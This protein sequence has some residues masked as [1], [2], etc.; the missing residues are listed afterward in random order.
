VAGNVD[1]GQEMHF[2]L[3]EPVALARFAASAL[4]VEGEAAGSVA[5]LACFLHL[6]EQLANRREQSGVRR[7]IGTRRAADRT[8]VDADD[9]VEVFE[10]L[11]FAVGRGL[12]G[13][14]VQ[15]PRHGVIERVADQGGIAGYWYARGA[16]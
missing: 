4:H 15:V 14:V 11:D 12:L 16:D 3:D 8:L 2:H 9:L 13:A 7:R 5:A 10:S 6:R 1:V